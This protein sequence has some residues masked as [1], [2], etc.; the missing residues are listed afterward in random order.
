MNQHLRPLDVPQK[1]MSKP[2]PLGSTFDQAR[3]IGHDKTCPLIQI[4]HP[5]MGIQGGKMI[6]GHFGAGIAD[7]GQQGGFAYIGE[8][9]KPYI[10]NYL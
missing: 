3:N 10:G 9:Y 1:V 8:A 6:I 5:Q 4:H 7:S 2:D